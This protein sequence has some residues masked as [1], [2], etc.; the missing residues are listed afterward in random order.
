MICLNLLIRERRKVSN[1]LSKFHYIKKKQSLLG[2]EVKTNFRERKM[3]KKYSQMMLL[4]RMPKGFFV[5]RNG[6]SVYSPR[7][8]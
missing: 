5:A 4:A 7:R 6:I 1:Q 2:L 3:K 8:R